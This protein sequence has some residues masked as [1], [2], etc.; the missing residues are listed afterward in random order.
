MQSLQL[1]ECSRGHREH[2]QRNGG[3]PLVARWCHGGVRKT[4]T[5]DWE[6][7]SVLRV[8]C[9]FAERLEVPEVGLEPTRPSRGTG[10]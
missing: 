9:R 4:L 8:L 6:L 7:L 2:H 3:R 10:F 5:T 1:D